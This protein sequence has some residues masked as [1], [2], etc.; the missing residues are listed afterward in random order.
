MRAKGL[1]GGL[2]L[3]GAVLGTTL[4]LGTSA[5]ATATGGIPTKVRAELLQDVGGGMRE[6]LERGLDIKAVTTTEEQ[7][8]QLEGRPIPAGFTNPMVYFV[9]ARVGPGRCQKEPCHGPL[10]SRYVIEFTVPVT[11]PSPYLEHARIAES[12]PDLN[13]LGVPVVLAA[14][15]RRPV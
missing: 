10:P 15:A 13:E 5:S 8:L 9:A 2:A 1:F 4:L 6:D 12:Y 11:K 7:A 14:N 3:I